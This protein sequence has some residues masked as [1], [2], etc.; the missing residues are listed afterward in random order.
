MGAPV[1]APITQRNPM[2]TR[3]GWRRTIAALCVLC[4]LALAPIVIPRFVPA[5][6]AATKTV[7]VPAD[8][9]GGRVPWAQNRTRESNNFILFWGEKSGTDPTTASGANRFDPANI[10]SQ[11]EN[12]YS[13]YVNTMKFTPEIS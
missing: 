10:L 5:A 1:G 9:S 4:G 3:I 6:A 13:F 11:L 2:I 12:L 8:W 7:H